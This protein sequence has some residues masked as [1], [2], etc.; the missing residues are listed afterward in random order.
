MNEPFNVV[1]KTDLIWQLVLPSA[2]FS[3]SITGIAVALLGKLGVRK[4]AIYASLL[5]LFLDLAIFSEAIYGYLWDLEVHA[6]VN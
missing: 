6:G 2:F 5:I 4:L 3:L 1:V